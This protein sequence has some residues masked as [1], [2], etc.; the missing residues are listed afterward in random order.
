MDKCPRSIHL[1]HLKRYNWEFYP[2]GLEFSYLPRIHKYR[3]RTLVRTSIVKPKTTPFWLQSANNQLSFPHNISLRPPIIIPC[4]VYRNC[5]WRLAGVEAG[6]S[7]YGSWVSKR[8]LILRDRIPNSLTL[9]R[10]HKYRTIVGQ[11][12]MPQY[13]Q[14]CTSFIPAH[15]LQKLCFAYKDIYYLIQ[16]LAPQQIQ[17]IHFDTFDHSVSD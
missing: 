2:G 15:V 10:I 13:T 3:T 9:P 17:C 11:F 6:Q 5:Q 7:I 12:L 14:N 16:A 4:S 1:L 8:I